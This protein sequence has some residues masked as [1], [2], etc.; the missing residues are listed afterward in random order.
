MSDKT[1][2]KDNALL[3]DENGKIV[4][5][6]SVLARQLG[7]GA[8]DLQDQPLKLVLGR[9]VPEDV[10]VPSLKKALEGPGPKPLLDLTDRKSVV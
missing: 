3:V 1:G 4:E 6:G 10:G 9:L 5:A 7:Y 2:V 8:S